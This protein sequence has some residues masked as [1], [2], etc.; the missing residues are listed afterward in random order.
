MV[1]P[2]GDL[3]IFTRRSVT[4]AANEGFNCL[5]DR[6]VHKSREAVVDYGEVT[7]NGNVLR[8][9]FSTVTIVARTI[10]TMAQQAIERFRTYMRRSEDS[11]RVSAGSIDRKADGLYS[12]NSGHTMMLSRHETKI[13]GDRIFMG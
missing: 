4:L 9:N 5:S 2:N 6:V 13:D 12:L 11:D 8:A 10:A 7:A 1:A 3:G